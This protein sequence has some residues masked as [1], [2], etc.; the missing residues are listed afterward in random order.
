MEQGTP[1]GCD[2]MSR[3][4]LAQRLVGYAPPE[5]AKALEEIPEY[6]LRVRRD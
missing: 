6:R 2:E 3:F 4:N 5:W 1:S